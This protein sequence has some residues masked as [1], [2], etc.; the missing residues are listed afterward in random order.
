MTS[1]RGAALAAADA[2]KNICD[3]ARI[4]AQRDAK[5]LEQF[6][7]FCFCLLFFPAMCYCITIVT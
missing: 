5:A 2:D 6:H 7:F 4:L 3:V 1:S